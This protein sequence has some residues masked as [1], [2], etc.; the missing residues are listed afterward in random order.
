[1]GRRADLGAGGVGI[2]AL[3]KAIYWTR[4]IR[5]LERP[6]QMATRT[7]KDVGRGTTSGSRPS[8]GDLTKGRG[9]RPLISDS[10]A[11]PHRQHSPGTGLKFLVALPVNLQ[12]N[13]P[14]IR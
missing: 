12:A 1:M 9:I 10:G 14:T 13:P 6:S 4:Q 7:M 11:G 8:R 5:Q 2:L 3:L